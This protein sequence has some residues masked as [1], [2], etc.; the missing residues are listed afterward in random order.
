MKTE[1]ILIEFIKFNTTLSLLGLG[2]FGWITAKEVEQTGKFRW[3]HAILVFAFIA[4]C[5]NINE[6]AS[7]IVSM[8]KES[9]A[10]PPNYSSNEI[11]SNLKWA[12]RYLWGTAGLLTA[13]LI[14][15]LKLRGQSDAQ[16]AKN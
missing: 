7:L 8:V 6:V 2:A 13:F 4:N 3:F 14:F 12:L 9:K 16:A 1:E 10:E 15:H 11:Q 5:L